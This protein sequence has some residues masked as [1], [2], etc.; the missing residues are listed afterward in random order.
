[1]GWKM[2]DWNMTDQIA[3]PENQDRKMTDQI[4]Q[5][6]VSSSECYSRPTVWRTLH[7]S[8]TES[9]YAARKQ[10]A[11]SRT[12]SASRRASKDTTEDRT[13]NCSFSVRSAIASARTL[14]LSTSL[15][16]SAT[17]TTLHSSRTHNR[18]WRRHPARQVL[19]TRRSN[20]R[21]L[22]TAVK[23]HCP[24]HWRSPCA[25][26]PFSRCCCCDGQRLSTVPYT[27]TMVLRLY[28]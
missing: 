28:D 1:M 10:N 2:Q 8:E 26:R 5:T 19:P 21:S 12:M 4:N 17:T 9:A 6:L 13:V 11:M 16:M 22:Q 3:R 7:D 27:L 14:S 23:F 15:P 25:V 20:L 18:T 24:A